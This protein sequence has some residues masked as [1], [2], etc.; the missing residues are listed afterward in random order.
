LDETI[1]NT[2]DVNHI[3]ASSDGQIRHDMRL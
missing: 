1:A 3:R 2:N